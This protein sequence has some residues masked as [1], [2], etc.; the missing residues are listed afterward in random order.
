MMYAAGLTIQSIGSRSVDIR[1]LVKHQKLKPVKK[2][3]FE[4]VPF[5]F[6]AFG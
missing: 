2:V 6:I 1:P 3:N 5:D 4:A